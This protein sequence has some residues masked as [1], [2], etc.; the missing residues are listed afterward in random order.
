[1]RMPL[2]TQRAAHSVVTSKQVSSFLSASTCLGPYAPSAEVPLA[3]TVGTLLKRIH[4]ASPV[5]FSIADNILLLRE[6]VGHEQSCLYS[7]TCCG[8]SCYRSGCFLHSIAKGQRLI[9]ACCLPA[10]ASNR[11]LCELRC[12]HLIT[13]TAFTKLRYAK[14]AENIV[15]MVQYPLYPRDTVTLLHYAKALYYALMVISTNN[16]STLQRK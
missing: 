12:R 3:Y 15:I 13:T 1:M 6:F 8:G 5:H 16:H 10:L 9:P 2:L 11:I 14:H 7:V 4:T